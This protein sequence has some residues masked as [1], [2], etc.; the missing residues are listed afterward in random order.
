MGVV[1]LGELTGILQKRNKEDCYHEVVYCDCGQDSFFI[2]S[3]DVVEGGCFIWLDND[4]KKFVTPNSLVAELKKYKY[5]A[6][7]PVVFV[8]DSKNTTYRYASDLVMYGNLHIRL[9]RN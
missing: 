6:D 3:F 1:T 7:Y 4:Y 8:D 2:N 5:Q 9:D